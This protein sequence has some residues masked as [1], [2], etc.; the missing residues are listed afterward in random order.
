MEFP[1]FVFSIFHHKYATPSH[2]GIP[3]PMSTGGFT[4]SAFGSGAKQQSTTT[5]GFGTS[6][7]GG[8]NQTG[9]SAFGQQQ[10]AQP[11]APNPVS[12]LLQSYKYM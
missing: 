10:N 1:Q 11:A 6:T 8:G 9:F 7:W 5:T 2:F 4:F 12:V 3:I